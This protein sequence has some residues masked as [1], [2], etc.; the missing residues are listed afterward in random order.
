MPEI[1]VTDAQRNESASLIAHCIASLIAHCDIRGGAV[2]MGIERGWNVK[3]AAST[4]R[5]AAK[6]EAVTGG[7]YTM[8]NEPGAELW[9]GKVSVRRE[10]GF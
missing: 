2:C 6:V 4:V 8:W 7:E 5:A 1:T 10:R 9:F 3:K